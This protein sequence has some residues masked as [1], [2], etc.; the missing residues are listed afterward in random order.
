MQ[1]ARTRAVKWDPEWVE[2]HVSAMCLQARVVC[3]LPHVLQC[4]VLK[5]WPCPVDR[6]SIATFRFPS[7]RSLQNVGGRFGSTRNPACEKTGLSGR[8]TPSCVFTMRPRHFC[9]ASQM[10]ICRPIACAR[11]FSCSVFFFEGAEGSGFSCST[12]LI[13]CESQQSERSRS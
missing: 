4:C 7:H 10:K 12:L 13:S 3:G 1:D 8:R 6:L 2:V 9:L 5:E 11:V